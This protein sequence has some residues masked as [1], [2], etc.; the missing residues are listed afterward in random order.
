M[1]LNSWWEQSAKFWLAFY[2]LHDIPNIHTNFDNNRF[3][4]FGDYY[5]PNKNRHRQ[6]EDR[7]TDGNGRPL[8]W[9]SRG[10]ETSRKDE[11]GGSP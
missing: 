7:Q 11:T 6:T 9:R 2:Y 5:L 1:P 8:F 3:S 10:H 4:S